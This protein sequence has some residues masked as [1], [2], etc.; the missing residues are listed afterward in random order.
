VH[1]EF[2]AV[3]WT[4]T[5]E[6]YPLP[7]AHSSASSLCLDFKILPASNSLLVVFVVYQIFYP[8]FF[9]RHI[10]IPLMFVF[11]F[12]KWRLT[13]PSKT[14][15]RVILRINGFIVSKSAF[16]SKSKGKPMAGF[17]SIPA[18]LQHSS[19]WINDGRVRWF[20]TLHRSGFL[21]G[22]HLQFYNLGSRHIFF[23][24]I[25]FFRNFV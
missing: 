24:N 17:P 7:E 16:H 14:S 13:V 8:G 9:W 15:K 12:G 22:F 23:Y 19:F 1:V 20:K 18:Q 11:C 6:T 21:L 4:G 5:T 10:L 2:I 3:N 25:I